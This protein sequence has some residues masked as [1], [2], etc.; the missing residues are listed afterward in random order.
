VHHS[1]MPDTLCKGEL[2]HLN[3]ARLPPTLSQSLPNNYLSLL[4]ELQHLK[5]KTCG[6]T[7]EFTARRLIG[8]QRHDR[9]AQANL[10]RPFLCTEY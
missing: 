10:G 5:M 1:L 4:T 3:F 6:Q 2:Y 7:S 8:A 9:E